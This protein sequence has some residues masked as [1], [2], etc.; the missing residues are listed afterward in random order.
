MNAR[1]WVIDRQRAGAVR[2]NSSQRITV[3]I[4]YIQLPVGGELLAEHVRFPEMIAVSRK[5]I[6]ISR[7][8][9]EAMCS[10]GTDC[11]WNDELNAICGQ[12]ASTAHLI[13]SCGVFVSNC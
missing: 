5:K 7:R 13:I 12:N 4:Q 3:Q 11:V 9:S 1:I 8:M 10:N 2:A 6:K